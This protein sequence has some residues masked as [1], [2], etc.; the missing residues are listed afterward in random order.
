MHSFRFFR[1]HLRLSELLFASVEGAIFAGAFILSF[2][3]RWWSIDNDPTIETA[4]LIYDSGI[5]AVVFVLVMSAMG[6]YESSLRDGL[7]GSLIRIALS[8]FLGS[9]I[10]GALTFF[11]PQLA[12]WRSVLVLTVCLSFISVT[13]LRFLL[14]LKK[15]E[16]FTRKALIYGDISIA[17]KLLDTDHKGLGFVGLVTPIPAN[18]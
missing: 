16:F 10:L 1:H 8:L 7:S 17:E 15:P 2:Y 18:L 12:L 6:L 4:S 3:L 5:I 11:F 13:G 9:L 14:S